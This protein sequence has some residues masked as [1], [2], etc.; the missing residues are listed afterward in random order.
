MAIIA[1]SG[2]IYGLYDRGDSAHAGIR[3]VIERERDR[4]VIPS[5]V[6]GE[7]DYLLRS[8]IGVRSV[9]RFLSDIAIGAFQVECVTAEDLERCSVL[10]AKYDNLD[11]GLCDV[12]VIAVAERHCRAIPRG[13][14]DAETELAFVGLAAFRDPLRAGVGNAVAELSNAGVRTI[15]A[16]ADS[17]IETKSATGIRHPAR[18]ERSQ[19]FRAQPPR[20]SPRSTTVWC[21]AKRRSGIAASHRHRAR[22]CVL[23]G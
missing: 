9:S 2:G 11:L 1:D 4:I 21:A 22:T 5:P 17:A 12:S 7:I 20:R 19:P 23:R 16:P 6:L 18:G 3:A 14:A 13:A 8:R 10:V 15:V